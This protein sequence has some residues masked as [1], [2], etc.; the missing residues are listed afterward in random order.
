MSDAPGRVPSVLES[1]GYQKQHFEISSQAANKF[2]QTASQHQTN[3]AELSHSDICNI[4]R[5]GRRLC[6]YL[7]KFMNSSFILDL[8]L[9]RKVCDELNAKTNL[10]T[11]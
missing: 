11:F 9:C 7:W 1:C 6:L 5:I 4:T 8:S 10:H 3:T 2:S